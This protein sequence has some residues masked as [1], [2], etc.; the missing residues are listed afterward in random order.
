MATG[1]VFPDYGFAHNGARPDPEEESAVTATA[2]E[3]VV[4]DIASK[5]F[6]VAKERQNGGDIFSPQQA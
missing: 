4:V 6:G 3:V 2:E 5:R 1:E